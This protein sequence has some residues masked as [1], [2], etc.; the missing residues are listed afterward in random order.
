MSN[1]ILQQELL[2]YVQANGVLMEKAAEVHAQREA[3]KGACAALIPQA[4][5]A[6]LDNE[7]IEP[8]QKEAAAQY[9]SDPVKVLEILIKTAGH[10]NQAEQQTV[11]KP[12]APQG[13]VKKAGANN[14]GRRP[15]GESD[16][17]TQAMKTRLGIV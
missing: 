15:A 12:V 1:P 2:D 7:R 10:R 4:V 5:Q 3:E 17:A 8:H 6:L 9:L 14:M 11:G 16:A 13:Q